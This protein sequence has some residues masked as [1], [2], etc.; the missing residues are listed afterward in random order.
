V[1]STLLTLAGLAMVPAALGGDKT[2]RSTF[3]DDWKAIQASPWLN[4]KP[5]AAWAKLPEAI[6][7]GYGNKGWKKVEVRFYDAAGKPNPGRPPHR[8]DI[9]FTA[10]GSDK[11]FP[12]W[13]N[14]SLT[15]QAEQ[16]A[17]TFVIKGHAD[18]PYKIAYSFKDGKLTLQGSYY[19]L[20][21]QF[22]TPAVFDGEY[23]P[24]AAKKK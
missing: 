19:S 2:P 14:L 21:P 20:N 23:T 17:R 5:D 6:K 12:T 3:E 16:G 7:Q 9:A 4:E 22:S 1:R 24:V 13:G 18:V 8:V 10:V 11:A 15:F